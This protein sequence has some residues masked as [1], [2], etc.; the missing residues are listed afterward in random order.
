MLVTKT[1]L[2]ANT[3]DTMG[4][5]LYREGKLPEAEGYIAAAWRGEQSAEQGEHLAELL[6]KKGDKSAALSIYELA[7]ATI[8][9]Y[10]SMGVKKAPGEKKV[11]LEKRV[12]ALR[13]AGVKPSQHEAHTLQELRTIQLGAAKG[14]SGTAEYRLLLSEGKVARAEAAGSKTLEGGQER[15]KTLAVGGF[16][17]VGSQAQ[18]VRSGFLNCHANVCEVVL[19]P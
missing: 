12:E 9:D 19:E 2:I 8:P 13:K 11:E 14:M 18:L 3:W 10:D 5:I 6:E 15:V 4:W 1:R 16:W 17:P 7:D